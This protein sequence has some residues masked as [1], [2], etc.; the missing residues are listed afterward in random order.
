MR[1]EF[2]AYEIST[3]I[4]RSPWAYKN[5][6]SPCEFDGNGSTCTLILSCLM[7]QTVSSEWIN[8]LSCL[9]HLSHQSAQVQYYSTFMGY[10]SLRLVMVR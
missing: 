10:R 7:V 1:F 4:L 9:L 8:P 5:Q 2:H 3:L 6:T